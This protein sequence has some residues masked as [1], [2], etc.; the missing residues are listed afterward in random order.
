MVYFWIEPVFICIKYHDVQCSTIRIVAFIISSAKVIENLHHFFVMLSIAKNGCS[1]R[2]IFPLFHGIN[3]KINSLLFDDCYSQV[4]AYIV[5]VDKRNRKSTKM[6]LARFKSSMC[7]CK[8]TWKM[9]IMINSNIMSFIKA[10]FPFI[11]SLI[12]KKS[13][14][15]SYANTHLKK[16]PKTIVEITV[17]EKKN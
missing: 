5:I 2:M 14:S 13:S 9:D 12:Q 15:S 3:R 1:E 11:K 6:A 4:I 16:G 8:R 7:S 17:Q 10:F